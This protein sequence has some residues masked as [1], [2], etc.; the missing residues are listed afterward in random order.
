MAE[1][2]LVAWDVGGVLL[3]NGWDHDDR[4]AACAAFGVAPEEFE[5]RHAAQV[6]AFERGR[7]SLAEYL[8]ATLGP[9]G[10]P[11]DHARF[12]AFILD[13]SRA[14]PETLAIARELAAAGAVRQVTLNDES[15][16]LNDYRIARFGLAALFDAF[17][18]SCYTGLRK[19]APEA[20]DC[21]LGV[22]HRA[23]PEVVFVD[24]RAENVAAAAARGLRAIQ[25][26]AATDLRR[27][28]AAL[29]VTAHSRSEGS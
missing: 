24:D 23:G 25:Y 11:V 29:G 3:S 20:F 4:R 16:E 12:R 27:A 15:R 14:H 9:D 26:T 8:T 1:V 19:P 28:F 10:R 17:F 22:L 5:A 21:L 7:Q 18:S 2:A 6:D 13:R